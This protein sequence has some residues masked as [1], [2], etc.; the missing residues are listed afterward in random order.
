MARRE[1]LERLRD[2]DS[3]LL[4]NTLDF[5]DPTPAHECY[6]SGDIQ[7]QTPA[8]GPVCGVAI[9]CELDSSTPGMAWDMGPFWKILEQ[10]E[11]TAEP[12]ILVIK[13]AGSRPEHECVVGD[14]MAKALYAAGCFGAVT[15][16]QVR[17]V[18]GLLTVPFSTHARGRCVHHC[19][20]GFK[21]V[22]EP[23]EVGGLTIRHGEVLHAGADGVIRIPEAALD[24]LADAAP[25]LVAAEHE[26]HEIYRRTDLSAREKAGLVGGLLKK[27]GFEKRY[28]GSGG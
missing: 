9:T 16:G 22:Q 28:P 14:G 24:K 4:V 7:S 8:L 18:D 1:Q 23:V 17:D 25:R 20:F 12:V 3:S 21:S 6:M 26:Q 2:F 11:Q 19:A 15:D 27:H 13:Q 10:I 5:V